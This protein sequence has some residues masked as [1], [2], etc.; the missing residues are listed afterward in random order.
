MQEGAK[1]GEMPVGWYKLGVIPSSNWLGRWVWEDRCGLQGEFVFAKTDAE[2]VVVETKRYRG[3]MRTFQNRAVI[4][5]P[6]SF[7]LPKF[8]HV[9]IL[10]DRDSVQVWN[11]KGLNYSACRPADS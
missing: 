9:Y 10:E 1:S 11:G 5:T 6:E 3:E 7:L 4:L 2:Y 8:G